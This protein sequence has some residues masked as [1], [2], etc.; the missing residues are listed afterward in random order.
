VSLGLFLREGA[1]ILQLGSYVFL[2]AAWWCLF[3]T[4]AGFCTLMGVM[5]IQG[6]IVGEDNRRQLHGEASAAW[7]DRFK[8]LSQRA[9]WALGVASFLSFLAGLALLAYV[10]TGASSTHIPRLAA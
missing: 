6:Y 10:A 9:N 2:R 8:R 3:G 1:P 7:L 4:M 5:V